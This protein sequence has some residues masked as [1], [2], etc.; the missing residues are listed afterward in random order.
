MTVAKMVEFFGKNE[1]L[2]RKIEITCQRSI[3]NEI[4][5]CINLKVDISQVESEIKNPKINNILINCNRNLN[6][7]YAEECASKVVKFG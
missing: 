5:L 2:G 1:Y 7:G 6:H 4:N 3:V